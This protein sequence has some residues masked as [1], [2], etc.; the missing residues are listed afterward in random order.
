M[1]PV[2]FF[3]SCCSR[4]PSN[5]NRPTGN[6]SL[7]PVSLA[8]AV[9][10]DLVYVCTLPVFTVAGVG[11]KAGQQPWSHAE[12]E[13]QQIL[14]EMKKKTSLLTDSSWIRQRSSTT[15]TNN[16]ND[17]PSMRRYSRHSLYEAGLCDHGGGLKPT[18]IL[19][20]GVP[21]YKNIN[22]SG[23]HDD[24]ALAKLVVVNKNSTQNNS[25]R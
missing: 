4:R 9:I 10:F 3:S 14:N 21:W 8:P 15:I 5:Q 25:H 18:N 23:Y 12:L 13:R 20:T 6:H 1:I 16:E 19:L 17:M 2:W 11:E 7:N 24:S 22:Y